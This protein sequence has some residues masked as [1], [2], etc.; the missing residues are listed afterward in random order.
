MTLPLA[1]LWTALIS[2]AALGGAWYARKYER[3][4]AL[5]AIFVTLVIAANLIASKTVAF[6]LGFTTLF[7]PAAVLIFS[8]T[9]LLTDIVNE[10][11]G[12]REAQR[13]IFLAF[14]A[15]VIFTAFAYLAISMEGAPFFA[16][17][18]AFETVLGAVPRIA[19]AG[20][21]AFLVSENLDAYLFAWFKKV[22]NGKHL[23]MRNAFSSLP[24]M[25]VDSVL[26]VTLAF[27]GVMPILPLI[28]GLT[29]MKWLVG[30]IDIPF[31]YAS[32]AVLK[33]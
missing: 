9:F 7:A 4:D 5:L 1:I 22:T 29:V 17:Q 8:V 24:A 18:A 26:F 16:G 27:Y 15:Q 19:L 25:L 32:R 10:K 12:R 23:W 3:Y 11:F 21:I 14:L 20:W 30:I 33:K 28:I 31:M 6:D 13:M 2:L